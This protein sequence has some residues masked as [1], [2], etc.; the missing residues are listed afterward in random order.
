MEPT[1]T[2]GE[3]IHMGVPCHGVVCVHG[4]CGDA[5][6]TCLKVVLASPRSASIIN[7]CLEVTLRT[8]TLALFFELGNV[9]CG[10]GHLVKVMCGRCDAELQGNVFHVSRDGCSHKLGGVG[11]GLH[12]GVDQIARVELVDTGYFI[13]NR[14][15][16]F[17]RLSCSRPQVAPEHGVAVSRSER[18]MCA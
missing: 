12:L 8:I 11:N 13:Q 6:L 9:V 17:I 2:W 7:Y 1:T 14:L 15:T 10:S 3:G 5:P 16:S 18:E 4:E